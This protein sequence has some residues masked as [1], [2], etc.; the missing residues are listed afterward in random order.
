MYTYSQKQKGYIS[1]KNASEITGREVQLIEQLCRTGKVPSKI[2][3]GEWYVTEASLLDYFNVSLNSDT[4]LAYLLEKK[5]DL[6]TKSQAKKTPVSV[7]VGK[8]VNVLTA[9]TLVFGG[10]YISMTQEGRQGARETLSYVERTLDR[11][12]DVMA[13]VGYGIVDTVQNSHPA[14]AMTALEN[15]LFGEEK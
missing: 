9:L 15:L 13:F 11:A 7:V 1:A 5:I 12:T 10:Y 2:V 14:S 8:T 6:E 3:A 4:P